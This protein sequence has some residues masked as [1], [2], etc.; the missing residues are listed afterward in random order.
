MSELGPYQPRPS[1]LMK[2]LTILMLYE[3]HVTTDGNKYDRERAEKLRADPE[4]KEWLRIMGAELVLKEY[5][6]Q[7]LE[8]FSP[9]YRA[10][11]DR[12]YN[13]PDMVNCAA[14][15]FD[16]EESRKEWELGKKAGQDARS[17]H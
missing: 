4:V 10:G 14:E 1:L 7:K 2:L 15:W 3:E 8:H 11:F 5:D 16:T 9:P 17:R 13:G 6:L 12:G